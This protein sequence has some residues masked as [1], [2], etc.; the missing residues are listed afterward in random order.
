MT[1]D[2]PIILQNF[3]ENSFDAMLLADSNGNIIRANKSFFEMTGYD[4]AQILNNK[5]TFSISERHNKDLFLL[6]WENLKSDECSEQEIWH[7]RKNGE[8][9]LCSQKVS[10]IRD[11]NGELLYYTVIFSD[12]FRLKKSENQFWYLAHYDNLTGLVNRRF[13]EQR[14]AEEISASH[15]SDLTGGLLF[16]DLDNFKKINDSLGHKTGDD[17]LIAVAKLIQVHLRKED[18]FCRLGGDEFVILLHGLSQ[19]IETAIKMI[20]TIIKKIISTLREPLLINGHNLYVTASF[21][22]TIFPLFADNAENALKQADIAMY[23]AK[24]KGKNTYSFYHPVMQKE[25]DLRL[26]FETDL[27]NSISKNHLYLVYQPQYNHNKDVLGYEVLVRWNHP[28]KGFISPAEFIPMAEESGLIIELGKKIMHDA[29]VQLMK[30][31]TEGKEIP[32]ISINV[33][34]LQFHHENFIIMVTDIFTATGVNPNKITLEIT[35]NMIIHDI[36][37]IT[38]KMHQLKKLGVSF[39]IDDFGTGY[40]S[41][42]YL[43]QMPIDELKIDQ[44]FIKDMLSKNSDATIV[45]TIINMAQQLSLN[46]I[47]EGVEEKEQIYFLFKNGCDGFQGYCLNKPLEHHQVGT[48]CNIQ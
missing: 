25:A 23:S 30:W 11:S 44:S 43:K 10:I 3:F 38:E 8:D 41:L 39:S 20:G 37:G 6:S 9:F 1:N 31:Q 46:L 42:A 28:E 17:V 35:E 36:K 48:K 13:L 21:G 47:A 2:L 5:I 32:K 12:I 15:R 33:S 24:S 26:T 27:R 18:V 19:D 14:L 34:P 22:V 29:C 45:N 16:F 40:S 7:R 4:N